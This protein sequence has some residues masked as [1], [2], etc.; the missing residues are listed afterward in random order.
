MTNLNRSMSL[1]GNS[2]RYYV[3]LRII[4]IAADYARSVMLAA[5]HSAYTSQLV[6]TSC[7]RAI[8]DRDARLA[9]GLMAK[10]DEAS[11]HLEIHAGRPRLKDPQ[12][13]AQDFDQ[14]KTVQI[15][16]R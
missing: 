4:R 15:N 12:L 8:A 9:V 6:L 10:H 1:V 7:A 3:H 13:F 2:T 16:Q 14:A 11:E 5:A